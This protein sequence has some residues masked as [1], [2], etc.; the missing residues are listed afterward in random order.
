MAILQASGGIPQYG[1]GNYCRFTTF[2]EKLRVSVRGFAGCALRT[3]T[4]AK[5]D[6]CKSV[7]VTSLGLAPETIVGSVRSEF[8]QKALGVETR[9]D[10]QGLFAVYPFWLRAVLGLLQDGEGAVCLMY[11]P[12]NPLC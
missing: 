1:I 12:V 6:T 3:R 7:T 5:K 2:P 11:A 10:A 8:N 4:L 9:T